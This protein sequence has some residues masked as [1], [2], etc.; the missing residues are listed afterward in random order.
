MPAIDCV[1]RCLQEARASPETNCGLGNVVE[2]LGSHA[3]VCTVGMGQAVHQSKATGYDHSG[4]L[5]PML[6]GDMIKKK[7]IMDEEEELSRQAQ[8]DPEGEKSAA[9]L[10][11]QKMYRGREG[12]KVGA[13]VARHFVSLATPVGLFVPADS[14]EKWFQ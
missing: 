4:M 6:S 12:R 2:S 13:R 14:I 7:K 10:K 1:D 11:L 9:A 3:G 5:V 8:D